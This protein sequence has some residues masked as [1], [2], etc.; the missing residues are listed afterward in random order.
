MR[1]LHHVRLWECLPQICRNHQPSQAKTMCH[2]FI[3]AISSR[4]KTKIFAL[5][6]MCGG[7]AGQT[8][9]HIIS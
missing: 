2:F 9:A 8:S 3:D 5:A 4:Q 6:V 7:R 1:A